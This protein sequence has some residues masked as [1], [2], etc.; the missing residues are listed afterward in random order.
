[1]YTYVYDRNRIYSWL[2]F[3]F[4]EEVW[5]PGVC[6]GFNGSGILVFRFRSRNVFFFFS[7]FPVPGYFLLRAIS[8]SSIL[9]SF[10]SVSFLRDLLLPMISRILRFR[11]LFV[12]ERPFHGPFQLGKLFN[13]YLFLR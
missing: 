12:T 5:G 6:A 4:I 10:S 1:M 3:D 8:T 2:E 11:S 9:F 7:L 13:S